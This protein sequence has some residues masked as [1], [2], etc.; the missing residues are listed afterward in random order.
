MR[1]TRRA[2]PWVV[3]S[4][5]LLGVIP[6]VSLAQPDP[7]VL[8]DGMFEALA[9]LDSYQL[10]YSSVTIDPSSHEASEPTV[11]SF[12]LKKPSE[13]RI[14]CGPEA[15]NG[16]VVSGPEGL[17]AYQPSESRYLVAD[18]VTTVEDLEAAFSSLGCPLALEGD[19]GYIPWLLLSTDP[20]AMIGAE[21]EWTYVG[22]EEKGGVASHHVVAH[23]AE[24]M[25]M[26]FWIRAQG[27]P[28]LQGL[29][30]FW[31]SEEDGPD[32][33]PVMAEAMSSTV[34]KWD[35]ARRFRGSEFEFTVPEGAERVEEFPVDDGMDVAEPLLDG[36]APDFELE[37]V[38]GETLKLADLVKDSDVTVLDFWATWCGPCREALPAYTKLMEDYKGKH[39]TFVAVSQGDSKADVR[40][41]L[42]ELKIRPAVALDTDC[43]VGASYGATSIPHTVVID[44]E[45]VIRAVHIGYTP[46]TEDTLREEIDTVL[47]GGTIEQPEEPATTGG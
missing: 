33:E 2:A 45:G 12:S 30:V 39:V 32:G 20:P 9:A 4:V 34:D 43:A 13:L 16:I 14:F 7:K 47:A 28:L 18:A 26:H 31:Q 1:S 19:P 41:C 35:T 42:K 40:A 21:V 46:G 22:R 44:G 36:P 3:V 5:A 37:S 6:A 10:T 24:G 15:E 23:L 25:D 38:S 8:A 11:T 29:S 17:F 27:P